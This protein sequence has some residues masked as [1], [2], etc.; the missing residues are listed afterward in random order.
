[1]KIAGEY[2][3]GSRREAVWAALLD[4]Q[5]L[6]RTLP[7]CESLERVAENQ[8]RGTLNVAIGPVKGQFQ[9]TLTLSDL[10][11]LEGYHMKLD[12]SGPAGFMRGEGQV[13]LREDGERTLLAYDLDAQV[14]GRVA[15]VGQRLLD[16]SA[17]SIAKQGLEGLERVLDSLQNAET[18]INRDA[19]PPLPDAPSHTEFAARMARDVAADL[20][21]AGRRPW[22]LVA[23]LVAAGAIAFFALR[24]CGG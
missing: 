16:S 6:A 15:G 9:G 3:F 7:G 13:K 22:L 10:R 17:N 1:M 8:Y 2:L 19:T 21:P 4:P 18:F 20:V 5:L 24:S 11:P 14:G 12:G 23:A